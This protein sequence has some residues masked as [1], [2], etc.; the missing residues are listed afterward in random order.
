[1][2]IASNPDN[3]RTGP[4]AELTA[5]ADIAIAPSNPDILYVATGEANNRQTTSYGDG[6]YTILDTGTVS[7][8]RFAGGSYLQFGPS[9][10]QVTAP[11]FIWLSV[12]Q[13]KR[14]AS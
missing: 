9:T 6:L 14:A 10:Q 5:I 12:S 13:M 7:G 11:T 2:T 3:T 1:M 8:N 4:D